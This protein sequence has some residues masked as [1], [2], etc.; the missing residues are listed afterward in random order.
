MS[1]KKAYLYLVSVISLVIAVV[2]AIMILNLGLKAWVFTK[3]DQ[4]FYSMPCPAS[5]TP[6]SKAINCDQATQD[7]QRKMDEENRS[8]QRQNTAAEALAMVLVATPV[9]Y[10][11]WKMARREV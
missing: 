3:A 7:Q 6:D 1:L 5:M 8:A 10:F 4:N 9:W 2:G 11:H